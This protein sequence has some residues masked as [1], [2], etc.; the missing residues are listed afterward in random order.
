[1]NYIDIRKCVLFILPLFISF[2]C[3]AQYNEDDG[4]IESRN[5]YLRYIGLGGGATYQVMRDDA[6]SPIEYSKIGGLPM[7]THMKVSSTIYTDFCLRAS[8]LDLTH[9]EDDEIDVNV[10]TQRAL[11]DYRLLLK[12]PVESR[13]YDI[14]AG[15]ILSASFAGK[16]APHLLDAS[17]VYE[18]AVSLGLCGRITKEVV[19][20]DNTAFLA[21]DI[22]IPF[23]A[24]IS[25]PDYLNRQN[26]ADPE[27]KPIG[28]FFGNSATGSFGKFFRLQSRLALMYRLEN[29]NIIQ[30]G[31]EWDYTRMKTFN[32]AYFAEHIVSALFM[33]NY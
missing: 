6:I 18:Y 30:F 24:N 29:G 16:K 26:I 27:A 4:G 7:Y 12:V 3:F 32:K 28:D 2:S 33:F 25:R 1:M 31:Y 17:D 11:L 14:R 20:G 22:G 13:Y 15:G 19:L 21:L 8:Q 9:N 5:G 10:K 23:F